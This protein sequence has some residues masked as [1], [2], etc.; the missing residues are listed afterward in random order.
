M[1]IPKWTDL[2]SGTHIASGTRLLSAKQALELGLTLNYSENVSAVM[3]ARDPNTNFAATTTIPFLDR[4]TKV[5][6]TGVQCRGCEQSFSDFFCYDEDL[7][8][9][10]A[11]EVYG[12]VF[13]DV[14]EAF[15]EQEFV[16]HL[17]ECEAAQE[18]WDEHR[19]MLDEL[20]RGYKDNEARAIRHPCSRSSTPRQRNLILSG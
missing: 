8:V 1:S 6:E 9:E 20:M 11:A 2:S 18:M 14:K 19:K 15:T 5:R 17:E 13:E 4:Q 3:K 7:P 10:E 16:K 12:Q